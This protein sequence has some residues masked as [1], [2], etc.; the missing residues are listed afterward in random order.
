MSLW[1]KLGKHFSYAVSLGIALE[2]LRLAR[3]NETANEVIAS[4]EKIISSQNAKITTLEEDAIAKSEEL[5]VHGEAAERLDTS[6]EALKNTYS[7]KD[8]L[9]S[10]KTKYEADLT[11]DTTSEQ[12]A[13]L[14][15]ALNDVNQ[16]LS[17]LQGQAYAPEGVIYEEIANLHS[18]KLFKSFYEWA[19]NFRQFTLTLESFQLVALINIIYY[20]LLIDIIFSLIILMYGNHLIN[21]LNLKTRFPRFVRFIEWRQKVNKFT[22]NFNIL[23]LIIA[24][25]FGLILN[26]YMFYL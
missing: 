18:K 22:I 15:D 24:I 10:L 19:E 6:F 12:K 23:L 9:L 21:L 4:K 3:K 26:I 5:L 16:K 14:T 17:S 25:L 20:L 7:S 8:T 13:Q 11:L 1:K 2:G